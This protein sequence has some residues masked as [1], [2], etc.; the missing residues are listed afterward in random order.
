MLFPSLYKTE[1]DAKLFGKRWI[2]PERLDSYEPTLA[3]KFPKVGGDG[4]DVEV[5]V[6]AAPARFYTVK[7][8][9]GKNSVDEPQAG[10]EVT[11]GSGEDIG[12]LAI[13]IAE[14]ISEGMIGF[15][16]I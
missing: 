9:P 10:F 14:A 13:K 11:T 8:L 4:H 2:G 12:R 5:Y 7:A 1:S 3:A 15:R 6:Q 16:T